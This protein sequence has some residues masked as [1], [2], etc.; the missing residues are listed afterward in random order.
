MLGCLW[1]LL[2]EIDPWGLAV[3]TL[4]L[5]PLA[6][7]SLDREPRGGARV[8]PLALVGFLPYWGWLLLRGRWSGLRRGKGGVVACGAARMVVSIRLQRGPARCFLQR[9]VGLVPGTSSVKWDGET[10][11]LQLVAADPGSR[12]A[13]LTRVRDLEDRVARVFGLHPPLR[14]LS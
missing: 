2:V 4:V 8:R 3:G 14:G 6:W 11:T 1:A 7:V 9:V 10:L 5:P 13:V 12:S